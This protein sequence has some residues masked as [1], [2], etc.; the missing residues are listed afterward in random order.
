MRR[1][2]VGRGALGSWCQ[3]PGWP[4]LVVGELWPRSDRKVRLVRLINVFK[5]LSAPY[6]LLL[7][8]VLAVFLVVWW[9]PPPLLRLASSASSWASSD[10]VKHV[11]V[12]GIIGQFVLKFKLFIYLFIF[13]W[14]KI[15]FERIL[16]RCLTKEEVH[17]SS[18]A[19]VWCSL[20]VS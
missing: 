3:F 10:C 8:I 17:F 13:F 1:C 9:F 15:Q 19:P 6:L 12:C 2:Q 20:V 5:I 7:I 4:H 16:G 14:Y 18:S 11:L